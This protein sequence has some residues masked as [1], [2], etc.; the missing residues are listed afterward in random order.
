[1]PGEKPRWRHCPARK[2]RV[3]VR[4]GTW[5]GK[6]LDLGGQRCE[7][8]FL[9]QK[10][11]PVILHP[12]FVNQHAFGIR[13]IADEECAALANAGLAKADLAV[14][15]RSIGIGLLSDLRRDWI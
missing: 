2:K 8:Q 9:N 10:P 3:L 7:I 6:R 14:N 12:M 11:A 13:R 4:A 5:R 15:N 1:M